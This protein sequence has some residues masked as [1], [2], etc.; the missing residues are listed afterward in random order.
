[1]LELKSIVKDYV[2]GDNVT[3]ALKGL[4][5]NFRRSEFVSILG[6]S[7]CGKTT[8]LNIIGGLDRYTSGDLIIEGKSTKGYTDRDW[9][10]YR[11]HSIGFVFQTYNL[12]SHLNILGNVELA[13]TI[14]GVEKKER[15][16][17]ALEALKKV[18][19]GDIAKKKPN[20][21]SGGQ[22]QRVA[23]ARALVN[24]P[25]ILLADEP[26]GALDSETSVQIMELLK[27]VAKDRLVIMVTHNPDLA[28]KYSSRII[29]MKDGELMTDSNPFDGKDEVKPRKEEASKKSKMSMKT[30]FSLSSRNLL[31]KAKRTVLVCFAGSIGII[32][33]SAV[34]GVSQGVTNYVSGMQD[35]MLSGN[36]VTISKSSLD[37]NAM[38]EA[39]SSLT[40]AK[41][42]SESHRDGY[43]DVDYFVKYLAEQKDNLSSYAV[44]NE[45]NQQYVD[46]VDVMP[47]EY[48]GAMSKDFGIDSKLNIF[49][50]VDFT[51]PTKVEERPVIE[52]IS[53]V[54][55]NYLIAAYTG[56]VKTTSFGEFADMIKLFVN[57][58]NIAPNDNEYILSQYDILAGDIAKEDDEMMIVV[59]SDYK[60][61]DIFLGQIGYYS[62]DEFVDV[63]NKYAQGSEV[64]LPKKDFSYDE[65]LGKGENP[66]HFYY[67]P[68]NDIFLKNNVF[69][70]VNLDAPDFKEAVKTYLQYNEMQ[71]LTFIATIKQYREM[72]PYVYKGFFN[73]DDSNQGTPIKV[74]G[75]LKPKDNVQYGCLESGF[76]I[77]N[78]FQ[79]K[80]Q[81]DGK[82]AE[83]TAKLKEILANYDPDSSTFGGISSPMDYYY[84][85]KDMEHNGTYAYLKE[86]AIPKLYKDDD[87]SIARKL[88]LQRNVIGLAKYLDSVS[89]NEVATGFAVINIDSMGGIAS[90]SV[91]K[92]LF[93]DTYSIESQ[94]NNAIASLGGADLPNKI[95]IYPRSFD[96]KYL[97]T[98]Y[99][100][101]WNS[102]ENFSYT[103][104]NGDL[105]ITY[106]KTSEN[107][108]SG[109][110]VRQDIKYTDNLEIIIRLINMM[111]QIITI[112]LVAFTSLSLVVSTVMI[113]IITYVSVVERVKE[114]GI[115]RSLGG[116]KHDVSNLFNVET[117]LIGL[118][119]GVFGIAV[120]Y[121][122]CLILNIVIS[123][124]AGISVTFMLP[125]NYALI[126]IA[127]SI[128]LTLISGLIPAR[129][130]AHKDPVVALRIGE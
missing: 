83:I 105:V 90:N 42:I 38:L 129:I 27:E 53:H 14:G 102:D 25:E 127:I 55:L 63:I 120:T 126:I 80:L 85:Y 82:A 10:T 15:Q 98:E 11:N 78:K 117:F 8:T 23:I 5:V 81:K 89:K 30:A 108:P 104:P 116:R 123:V 94:L 96:D 19:L 87:T 46:Y 69:D 79:D 100:D 17:R 50:N 35:D 86:V 122:I 41:A 21:L 71:A 61:R 57:A 95:S 75:I 114:I 16:K 88:A 101:K 22:M 118:T 18:G 125:W 74:T 76:I 51:L 124:V 119:S 72:T 34:L 32:G 59:S 40:Q 70:G 91:I 130:A 37:L 47:K 1:M 29:T 7:G 49:T 110:F 43:I 84:A 44:K 121:L 39:S 13:L 93:G 12:I 106:S 26:T 4:S 31:A 33:V 3:H 103:N 115:I 73:K 65:L 56:I 2:N 77:S 45:I 67:Y 97:V 113:G 64:E 128:A 92:A 99:L 48:Y 66:K 109:A 107:V 111:I 36:P 52:N 58:V 60:L 112:A 68:D 6:P 28:E 24:D 62:Q 20:Q 54:S 9:D